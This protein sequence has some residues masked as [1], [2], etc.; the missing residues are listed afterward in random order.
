M[1]QQSLLIP[2]SHFGGEK[3]RMQR[4]VY[5]SIVLCLYK[6]RCRV[7]EKC[8]FFFLSSELQAYFVEAFSFPV[9]NFFNSIKFFHRKLFQFDILLAINDFWIGLSGGFPSWFYKCSFHFR[10]HSSWQ[11]GL[12]SICYSIHSLHLLSSKLFMIVYL[13]PIFYILMI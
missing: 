13:L 9:F 4:F 11:E 10:S 1:P 12:S 3:E 2:R 7:V 5:F 8:Q 6:L